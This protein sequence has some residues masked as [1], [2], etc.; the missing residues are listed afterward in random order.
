MIQGYLLTPPLP[1]DALLE[2]LA[3]SDQQVQR[4]LG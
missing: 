1:F 4:K 2:W 3:N